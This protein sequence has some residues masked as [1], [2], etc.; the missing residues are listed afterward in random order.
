MLTRTLPVTTTTIYDINFAGTIALY[1][2]KIFNITIRAKKS[3]IV[4]MPISKQKVR[5]LLEKKIP[6]YN[7]EITRQGTTTDRQYQNHRGI[8]LLITHPYLILPYSFTSL[9]I[10]Y[11]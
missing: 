10:L 7:N 9:L 3:T 8:L 1:C 4:Y 6:G 5:I 11:P 2:C